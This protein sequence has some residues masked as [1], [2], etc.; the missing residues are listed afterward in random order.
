MKRHRYL[1]DFGLLL[2]GENG[3][4]GDS[5]LRTFYLYFIQKRMCKE[6]TVDLKKMEDGIKSCTFSHSIKNGIRRHPELFDRNDTS[7][8]A[9]IG[10][11]LFKYYQHNCDITFKYIIKQ[12]P[13]QISDKYKWSFSWWDWVKMMKGETNGNIFFFTTIF[14]SMLHWVVW[15][16][17]WLGFKKG[18][19]Y[20][21]GFFNIHLIAWMLYHSSK[22]NVL[23]NIARSFVSVAVPKS[24]LLIRMLLNRKVKQDFT[25]VPRKGWP[26]QR[27][28]WV[29]YHGIDNSEIDYKTLIAGYALDIDIVTALSLDYL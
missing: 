8:D 5:I 18:S 25:L 10:W 11:I 26:W 21:F 4:K 15:P 17:K 14:Y 28:P 9:V 22:S 7:Q 12:L 13:R 20:P 23:A 16:L 24:N 2:K 27:L 19:S 29:K 1:D 6:Y 3:S